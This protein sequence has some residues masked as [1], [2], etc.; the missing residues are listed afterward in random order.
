MPSETGRFLEGMVT[1]A[2]S[3]PR[4]RG[5]TSVL[6]RLG[7]E[8]DRSLDLL[9]PYIDI[10]K[11]GW[12]LP[13]LL[14]TRALERR[15]R[16]IRAHEIHVSNGGTLLEIAISKGRHRK[17]LESLQKTGFDT[18]ELSEGVLDVPTRIQ[19]EVTEF[20][21]SRGLRLHWEVGRKSVH[22]QLSLE[23]TIAR[24]E[25]ALDSKPDI[26]IIEGRESGKGVEIYDANGA[27]K[28]D[29]VDRI[30]ASV[31]DDRLM[32]ETP[33]E[34]QQTE[35]VLRL[36]PDVNLGNVAIGSVAALE[37]Q[38][39]GLRGDTF[40]V[41]P[42]LAKTDASPAGK[43]VHHVLRTHGILDQGRIME[44]TGLNRRTVQNALDRLVGAHLVRTGKDSRDL[45]RRVYEC[46]PAS[47]ED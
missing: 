41:I 21:H 43:F 14:D 44:L 47:G 5:L 9:A 25:R 28:W 42:P 36:G 29:W 2:R 3:K 32:F 35:M 37:T 12:G 6:D 7:Q 19:R 24:A 20:A 4:E 40:G 17:A 26:V 34:I 13:L 11:F 8:T 30:R 38:R 31:P 1:T 45:R 23:E 27:I 18:V 39:E 16:A 22:H 10:W 33:L 46:L 15:V